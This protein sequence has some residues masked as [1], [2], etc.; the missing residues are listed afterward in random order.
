MLSPINRRYDVGNGFL[1]N[2]VL[3]SRMP[4]VWGPCF[5]G[6]RD[7]VAQ[8]SAIGI[9]MSKNNKNVGHG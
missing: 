8:M 5:M 9:G 4:V 3:F 6:I 1:C 7:G 2:F